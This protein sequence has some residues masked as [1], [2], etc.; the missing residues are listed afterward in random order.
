MNDGSGS[1]AH[2]LIG[3]T[4]AANNMF[5]FGNGRRKDSLDSWGITGGHDDDLISRFCVGIKSE[6]LDNPVAD[7]ELT[8]WSLK[9]LPMPNYQWNYCRLL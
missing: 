5:C 2:R 3:E 6:R 1:L 4:L 7:D 9:F 8:S